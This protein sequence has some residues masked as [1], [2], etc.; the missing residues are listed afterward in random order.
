MQIWAEKLLNKSEEMEAVGDFEREYIFGVSYITA[1]MSLRKTKE[2][3][4]EK[5][6]Y[7]KFPTVQKL[8]PKINRI[9]EVKKELEKLYSDF[10]DAQKA[11]KDIEAKHEHAARQ[12]KIKKAQE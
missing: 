4:S 8:I 7:D 11:A 1:V 3:K 12:E 6:Y 9:E 5:S 10:E 2:Y